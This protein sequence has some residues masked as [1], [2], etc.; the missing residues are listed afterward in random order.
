ML[1]YILRRI[2]AAIP[3]GLIVTFGVFALVFLMPGDPIRA[4]AG[5]KPF[6]RR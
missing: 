1:G 3:I 2:A 6:P 5:D 4:L